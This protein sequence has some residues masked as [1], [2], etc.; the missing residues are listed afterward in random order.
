DASRA[1]SVAQESLTWGFG[2]YPENAALLRWL[3]DYNADRK[4]AQQVHFYGIDLSGADNHGSFSRARAAVDRSLDVLAL[5]NPAQ[6]KGIATRIEPALASFSDR[7][8]V[9]LSADQSKELESA[10]KTIGETLS[11][12]RDELTSRLGRDRYEWAMQEI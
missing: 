12:R 7:D 3:H 10:L 5:V 6:A 1:Q 9:R 2:R 11:A 4:P 8:D